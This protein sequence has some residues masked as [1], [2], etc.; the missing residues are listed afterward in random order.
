MK[1]RTSSR[2]ERLAGLVNTL[3][4]YDTYTAMVPKRWRYKR[5]DSHFFATPRKPT[6]D[7]GY[8]LQYDNLVNVLGHVREGLQEEIKKLNKELEEVTDFLNGER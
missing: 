4:K 7:S 6:N 3:A 2:L 5:V 8:T 1:R